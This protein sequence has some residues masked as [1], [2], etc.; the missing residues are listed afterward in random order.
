MKLDYVLMVKILK[1]IYHWESDALSF[2]T[3]IEVEGKLNWRKD[4]K[5]YMCGSAHIWYLSDLKLIYLQ[6]DGE[7]IRVTFKG[8]EFLKA[9]A[10]H[11]GQEVS[12]DDILEVMGRLNKRESAS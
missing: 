1:C 3:C 10:D 5:N 8:A 9:L 7:G 6:P 12:T 11:Y 4:T 2:P